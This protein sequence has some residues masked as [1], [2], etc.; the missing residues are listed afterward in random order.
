LNPYSGGDWSCA[1]SHGTTTNDE[2][3]EY[4]VV[5]I[6]LAHIIIDVRYDVISAVL[7]VRFPCASLARCHV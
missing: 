4:L 1:K 7:S 3:Y 2:I 6:Y 5:L